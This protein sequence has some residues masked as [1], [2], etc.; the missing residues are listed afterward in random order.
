[1]RYADL[2]KQVTDIILRIDL[3]NLLSE[4]LEQKYNVYLI[5]GSLSKQIFWTKNKWRLSY[6]YDKAVHEIYQY[7]YWHIDKI[8][9]INVSSNNYI[10]PNNR[11]IIIYLP[12]IRYLN[13]RIKKYFL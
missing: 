13:K 3:D 7:I 12:H 5:W 6:Q 4:A 1:M 9:K 2:K 10:S 8:I 11:N